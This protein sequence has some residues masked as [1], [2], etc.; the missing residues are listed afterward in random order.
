MILPHNRPYP[1]FSGCAPP[2][3]DE[4]EGGYVYAGASMLKSVRV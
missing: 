3:S 1:V 4:W 2:H